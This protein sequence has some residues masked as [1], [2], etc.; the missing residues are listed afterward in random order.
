MKILLL[1]CLC[2]K[3]SKDLLSNVWH[4]DSNGHPADPWVWGPGVKATCLFA[5]TK[6]LGGMLICLVM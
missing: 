2:Y 5:R 6:L 4:H 3:L 1:D